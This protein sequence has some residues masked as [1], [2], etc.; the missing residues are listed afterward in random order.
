MFPKFLFLELSMSFVRSS[1]FS[2]Y[3]SSKLTSAKLRAAIDLLAIDIF[4]EPYYSS[5]WFS[6]IY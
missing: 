6:F 3:S 2:V 1:D 5:I 4:F